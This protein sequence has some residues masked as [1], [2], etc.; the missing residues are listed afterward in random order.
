MKEY[1]ILLFILCIIII[2]GF[3]CVFFPEKGIPFGE[4]RLFFPTL[5]E[6]FYKEKHLTAKEKLEV[7]EAG[8]R[9]QFIVDSTA[10]AKQIAYNDSLNFYLNFFNNHPARFH[11]PNNNYSFFED[12]FCRMDNSENNNEVIHILH[13]GDSQIEAD[14]ISGFIRQKLQEKFGGNGPGLIPAIQPIPSA[15][16]GQT[17]SGNMVRFTIAGSHVN[18][19]GH[20]RYGI[21]GQTTMINGTGRVTV[22]TRNLKNTFEN[23]K[24]FYKVRVFISRNS[25]DFSASLQ[26][27][28]NDP[29]TRTLPNESSSPSILTWE[30]KQPVRKIELQFSGE[31]EISAIA[32]DGK[33][34]VAVDNIPLRG[35]SGTFFASIDVNTLLPV[36]EALNVKLIIM[37]FGGNRMPSIK[38]EKAINDYTKS[39]AK[40]INHLQ[41]IYPAAKILFIGPADMSTMD[42]GRLR[43]RPHL[44][45]TVK[46]IKETVLENGA[47]FWDMF[48]VMGGEDSMIE[49]VK[50]EPAWASPDYI[51]FT[52][53]GAAKIAGMFYESL[54]IYYNYVQFTNSYYQNETNSISID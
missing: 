8:L 40:Q 36:L 54:M 15:S 10:Q 12:I 6:I 2:L 33:T 43:T 24:D 37:E 17:A 34:G 14:R 30:F 46:S 1:K 53:R 47:A 50:N 16:V 23:V 38:S 49:W 19:A 45:E 11:F 4:R 51:H 27:G 13:Y 7:L 35:S 39:I 32:L 3:L 29:I 48:E 26:I 21:L 44:I 5:E 42:I 20:N 41:T 31:A 28:E 22:A 18:Q 9:M 52:E 25:N